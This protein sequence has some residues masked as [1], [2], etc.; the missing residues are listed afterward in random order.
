MKIVLATDNQG[1][2]KE[3]QETICDLPITLVSQ[4]AFSISSAEETGLSFVEN[5]LIKARHAA[6][7]TGLPALADDSGLCVDALQGQPG[8]YSARYA[9]INANSAANIQKLQMALHDVPDEKRTARFYCAI[10][11]MR[12]QADPIPLICQAQWEGT[13]M[14]EPRGE[15]GFG[16]DPIFFVPDMNCTAA[17]L[18]A[19]I[20]NQISH[21]A[22]ALKAFSE[23][24]KIAFPHLF[25]LS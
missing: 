15:G 7:H 9:G 5:A 23:Q 20:K 21:R 19:N 18:P 12:H 25:D 22:K 11:L 8:I 17:E 1:K 6:L 2:L 24:F 4:N 16:Y 13:I 14:L 3:I 10:V